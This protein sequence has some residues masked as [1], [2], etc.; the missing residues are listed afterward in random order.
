MVDALSIFKPKAYYYIT[1]RISH[2]VIEQLEN[3]IS[4][5]YTFKLNQTSMVG[6][7]NTLYMYM[8][9]LQKS[10]QSITTTGSQTGTSKRGRYIEVTHIGIFT[11]MDL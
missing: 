9:R 11:R 3:Q 10:K 4:V 8:N 7:N 5:I 6:H 1:K 2:P